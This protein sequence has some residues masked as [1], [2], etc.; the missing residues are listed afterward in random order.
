MIQIKIIDLSIVH[1]E[2][3]N[4]NSNFHENLFLKK[5]TKIKKKNERLSFRKFQKNNTNF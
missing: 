1:G 3:G 4:Y 2:Q 5:Q